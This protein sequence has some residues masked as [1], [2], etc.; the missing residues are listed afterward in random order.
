MDLG[1]EADAVAA[2]ATQA[3]KQRNAHREI[4]QRAKERLSEE[5]ERAEDDY[6]TAY[7]AWIKETQDLQVRMCGCY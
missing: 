2:I 6:R 3:T 7:D 5:G 1:A 4:Q